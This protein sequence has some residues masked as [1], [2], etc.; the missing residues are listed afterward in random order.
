MLNKLFL[1]ILFFP[2]SIFTCAE[3]NNLNIFSEDTKTIALDYIQSF[4]EKNKLNIKGKVYFKKPSLFKITTSEPSKTELIVNYQDV[5]R[6]DYELNET[7][8]HKLENIEFQIPALLLLKSK[9]KACNFLKNTE[10]SE[11][12]TDVNIISKKDSLNKITYKD[13]FGTIT[14]ITFFDIKLND[15]L[16]KKIFDYNKS[17]SL[18]ILN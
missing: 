11:F 18:I 4:K 8:K 16:D 7:I 17:S 6:T 14:Q 12:I 5:F 2:L 9:P 15:E 10:K 1:V 3:L 13:Q